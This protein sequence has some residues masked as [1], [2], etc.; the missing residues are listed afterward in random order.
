M[1][2]PFVKI[3]TATLRETKTFRNSY[4][5]ASWYT[6]VEVPAGTVTDIRTDGY[7]IIVGRGE[8]TIVSSY[9]VNRV[10]TSSSAKVNEDV[11][12]PGR[13]QPM[14]FNNYVNLHDLA[15]HDVELLPGVTCEPYTFELQRDGETTVHH[16]HRIC[17]DGEPMTFGDGKWSAGFKALYD[18]QQEDVA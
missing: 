17:V 15:D 14:Q 5:T 2:R 7:W 6:D 16:S 4:E 11:G 1:S 12:K 8:G 13:A 3:G 9:F 10:F 18:A